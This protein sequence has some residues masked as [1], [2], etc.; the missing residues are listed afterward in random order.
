MFL[1]YL[2]LTYTVDKYSPL[3]C[4]QDVAYL[5]KMGGGTGE[6]GR[7]ESKKPTL[8]I[9][10]FCAHNDRQVV[11]CQVPMTYSG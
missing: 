5:R 11:L 9:L 7:G 1:S 3:L 8:N 10:Q 2:A 4:N 6:R